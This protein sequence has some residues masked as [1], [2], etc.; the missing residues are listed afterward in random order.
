MPYPSEHLGDPP[1]L[2]FSFG[3]RLGKAVVR[4]KLRRRVR[5]IFTQLAKEDRV[6][7]GVYLVG[8]S[9]SGAQMSYSSIAT[10]V[11]TL[12]SKIQKRMM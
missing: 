3:R 11:E 6:P 1:R 10:H 2:A 5:S 12:L 8:M 9:P 4:N 7:P